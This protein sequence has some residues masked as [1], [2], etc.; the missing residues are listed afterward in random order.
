MPEKLCG[1]DPNRAL[2]CV[3]CPAPA[4][5]DS[6]RCGG[7]DATRAYVVRRKKAPTCVDC[8]RPTH[9]RSV[10]C[11]PCIRERTRA[12]REAEA[13]TCAT[14]RKPILSGKRCPPCEKAL[15]A[16]WARLRRRM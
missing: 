10:R 2:S 12:R 5:D 7:C 4:Q 11:L 16:T 13:K 6:V 8:P 1:D 9:G 3:D 15:R 14:C